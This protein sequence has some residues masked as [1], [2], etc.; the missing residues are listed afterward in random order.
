MFEKMF[1]KANTLSL[2]AALLI[3]GGVAA[4]AQDGKKPLS[5]PANASVTVN[6]KTVSIAYSAPSM[7]GRKIFGGLVPNGKVWRTGANSATAL[8]TTA[9]MDLGDLKVPA[10][11]YTLYSLPSDGAW[12]LIVNKQ[13]GQWGTEYDAAQDLGR[14]K[15]TVKKTAA[16]VE[17]FSIKLS[18]AG[19]EGT[20]T[21]TWENTEGSVSF[22]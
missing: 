5:P 19:G 1:R 6:G 2:A 22:H 7:R 20:L 15:L 12:T 21:L 10:G 11:N 9:D 8:T 17:T 4:V 18:Q 3:A 13:T 14:V 16:P